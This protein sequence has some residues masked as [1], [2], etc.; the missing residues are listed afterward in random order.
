[1]NRQ[2]TNLK[3]YIFFEC[4]I[5]IRH[6]NLHYHFY[7]YKLVNKPRKKGNVLS[8]RFD[9][10]QCCQFLTSAISC[11]IPLRLL[12]SVTYMVATLSLSHEILY[13]L[14]ALPLRACQGHV[15][16]GILQ[17]WITYI[18]N[19]V[20]YLS[21]MEILIGE[22]SR[23]GFNP[24]WPIWITKFDGRTFFWRSDNLCWANFVSSGQLPVLFCFSK[25]SI[26]YAVL[27]IFL[28]DKLTKR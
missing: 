11:R 13:Y 3:R 14:R 21:F 10:S 5:W 7:N 9:T 4:A 15:P 12:G 27:K 16:E 17:Y 24:G 26:F 28:F 19:K 23:F 2:N 1:M 6:G 20:E 8:H 25:V 18:Q 22:Q